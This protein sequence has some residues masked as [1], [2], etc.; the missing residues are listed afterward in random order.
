MATR[1]QL[2]MPT[3]A[4]LIGALCFGLL[5]WCLA[6]I[7]TPFLVDSVAPPAFVPAAI[8]VGLYVGW[9]YIGSRVT[10]GYLAAIGHGLTAAFLLGVMILYVHAFSIMVGK[11]MR[12]QYGG[13]M[14]AVLDTFDLTLREAER[15]AD[16]T[17]L[18]TLV[19]G[20]LIFALI[21]EYVGRRYP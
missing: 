12:R 20:A 18:G 14:E 4:R 2:A 10:H 5:G 9:V 3:A 11:A 13:V 17:L 16:A 1:R 8:I 19:I 15:F 6:V 21:A 7:A